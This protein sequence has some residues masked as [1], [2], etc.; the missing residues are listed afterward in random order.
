MI[1]LPHLSFSIYSSPVLHHFL[2]RTQPGGLM[3]SLVR[4]AISTTFFDERDVPEG[5]WKSE[6]SSG[7]YPQQGSLR[8]K[9]MHTPSTTRYPVPR[10]GVPFRHAPTVV[11]HSKDADQPCSPGERLPLIKG[12]SHSHSTWSDTLSASSSE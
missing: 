4:N 7:S 6:E 9:D 3:L 5:S 1:S 12:R 11:K 10:P 2:T 8:C